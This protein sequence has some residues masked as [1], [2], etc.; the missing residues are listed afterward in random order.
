MRS[1]LYLHGFRAFGHSRL[2]NVDSSKVLSIFKIEKQWLL[3]PDPQARIRSNG[4][5]RAKNAV[6][7]KLK[8]E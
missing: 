8:Y 5:P 7:S 4:H 2:E 3:V 6:A 1:L